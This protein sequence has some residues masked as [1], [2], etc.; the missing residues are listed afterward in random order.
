VAFAT[1]ARILEFALTPP[2]EPADDP[3]YDE[4][5]Y[6]TEFFIT[7][8]QFNERMMND[9]NFAALLD[10]FGVNMLYPSGSRAQKRQHEGAARHVDLSHPTQLRAIPHNAV[11]QQ[12]GF[13]ANTLG[14]TGLAAAKDPDKFARLY[15]ASPRFR[16]IFAMVEWA[17]SFS[18]P[19]LLRAY[20]D[21]L[22]PAAWRREAAH[23][24]AKCAAPER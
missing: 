3:L 10:A 4:W 7:V 11:L 17:Q 1:L 20:V 24:A 12:L 22:D 15:R 19:D 2:G 16:R 18:D 14:G 13:L 6:L 9:P 21:A 5:D 23:V 8:R